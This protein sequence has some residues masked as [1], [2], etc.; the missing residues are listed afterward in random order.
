ML[1]TILLGAVPLAA[2]TVALSDPQRVAGA[3]AGPKIPDTPAGKQLAAWLQA[4]NSGQRDAVRRFVTDNY[5][6]SN[7]K[8]HPVEEHLAG[9]DRVYGDNQRLDLVRIDRSGNET[10]EALVYSPLTESWLR[11]TL[12][13]EAQAPHGITQDLVSFT[14]APPDP[15]ARGKLTDA[16]V[17]ERLDTYL[18]KLA[19]A[20][21]FSGTVILAKDGRPL[22]QRAFGLA[23]QAYQA[24]N[25]LDTKFNLGSMNKMFTAVAVAQLAQQGKLAFNDTLAKHLPDYPN[26]AVAEK[27]T[28]H[29]L[30]THTSGIG[31]YFNDKFREASKERFKAIKDYFPLFVDKPLEFEPGERFRYSN[32]GYMVLGPVVEKVSG[33]DYFDYVRE[34]VYKPAGMTNTD[35]YELDR[36]TPNLAVGYTSMDLADGRRLPGRKNNLFLHVVKGGPAGGG[37]STAEDLVRFATALRSHRLLDAEHTDLV[38]MG[39]VQSGRDEGS[40]Y[41]YGFFDRKYHGT[42]IVGHSGGFPGIN[43][44]LDMY[45]DKGYTVAVMSN[46]DP[47][48]ASRVADRLKSWLTQE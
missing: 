22:F 12:T 33:Q 9:F 48:A 21:L 20:D 46:Y 29:Q 2:L 28:L 26:K 7:L 42:R 43:A 39:K 17:V 38:L 1:R 13:V 34:H 41:G 15:A 31:D 3:E 10:I 44:Q 6:A 18:G 8:K 11:I 25:R 36:D 23:S 16:E 24:P 14:D 4:Y 35:A 37:F 27:V 5:A 47:P 45:L 30:L 32:A 40:R 19:K